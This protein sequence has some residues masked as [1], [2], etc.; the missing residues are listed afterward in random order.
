[1]RKEFDKMSVPGP[2]Q[3]EPD[4]LEWRHNGVPC[5][6]VRNPSGALCG[7]AAC[8]PEH[9]WHGKAF[10]MHWDETENPEVHGG[11]TFSGLCQEGGKICHVPQ[12]GEPDDVWWLGFDCAHSGDLTPRDVKEGYTLGRFGPAKYRDVEYV[13][14][15]ANSLAEQILARGAK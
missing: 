6:I 1:M 9:P 4:R 15:E 5:L 13:K 3:T 8:P 10:D 14:A 12:P 2:W 7:Y 11:I